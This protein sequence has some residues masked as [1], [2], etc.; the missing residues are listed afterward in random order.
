MGRTRIFAHDTE[1][2]TSSD[3]ESS[4]SMDNFLTDFRPLR[5]SRLRANSVTNEASTEPGTSGLPAQRASSRA[6]EIATRLRRRAVEFRSNNNTNLPQQRGPT[7]PKL[8]RL[9]AN[10]RL[11]R[12]RPSTISGTSPS[13][14]NR[15][16]RGS[17]PVI[18]SEDEE[19]GATMNTG[20][21]A[22]D[23]EEGWYIFYFWGD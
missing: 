1:H 20:A 7:S 2:E 11:V 3:E 21:A 23:N 9:E 22:G 14:F 8:P 16:G 4:G 13:L 17:R 15:R 5:S 12:Q 19:R 6:N 18:E 10:N